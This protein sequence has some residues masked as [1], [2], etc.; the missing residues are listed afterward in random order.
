MKKPVALGI[1]I[2]VAAASIL[3]IADPFTRGNNFEGFG[4]F[5]WWLLVVSIVY[6]ITE[7]ILRK[8]APALPSHRGLAFKTLILS[9]A[10]TSC[11][12]LA[13]TFIFTAMHYVS[14][15]EASTTGLFRQ[16][17]G[18]G[19]LVAPAR[20]GAGL[21]FEHEMHMKANTS[22][23][24]AGP[25]TAPKPLPEILNHIPLDL[26]HDLIFLRS[27]DHYLTFATSKGTFLKKYRF[28]DAIDELGDIEGII[29]R[30]GTWVAL[31]HI[32]KLSR[33]NGRLVVDLTTGESAIASRTRAKE[34]VEALSIKKPGIPTALLDVDQ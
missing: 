21:V 16:I 25:A 12:A 22:D 9:L 24:D 15:I 23:V 8:G 19:C 26:G 31:K 7:I 34:V 4:L 20:I 29:V 5:L 17:F 32:T 33:Q 30:R 27:E 11:G 3:A 13:L 1:V 10:V 2:V 6:G 18:L 28:S 14:G